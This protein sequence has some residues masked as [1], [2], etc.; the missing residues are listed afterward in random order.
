MSINLGVARSI[1]VQ[2]FGE[3]GQRTFRI[4]ILG[5]ASET[6]WLWVEKEHVRA[7]AFAF[8]RIISGLKYEDRPETAVAEELPE[9]A[10]REFRVGIIGVG[11][12]ESD[13]T[14]ALQVHELGLG[15]EDDPTLRVRLTLA[16]CSVVAAQLDEIV[17]GGRPVCQLCGLPI[18]PTGHP[19]GRRNGQ[20]KEAVPDSGQ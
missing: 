11:F 4:R 14:V 20:S 8:R 2:S 6:V 19:C 10:E 13:Q 1:D 9:A 3:P 17:E 7:L 16:Q 18:D 12:D 15:E 5:S